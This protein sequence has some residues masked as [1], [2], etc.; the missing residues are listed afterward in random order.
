MTESKEQVRDMRIGGYG[1]GK[2]QERWGER[3]RRR[4]G[5]GERGEERWGKGTG[6]PGDL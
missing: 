5:G 2:G 3:V 6:S 4:N 1:G